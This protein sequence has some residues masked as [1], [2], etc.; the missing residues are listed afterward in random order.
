[1]TDAAAP[2]GEGRSLRGDGRRLARLFVATGRHLAAPPSATGWAAGLG[3]ALATA[4]ASGWKEPIAAA[5]AG[6]GEGVARSVA[7][8]ANVAGAGATVT[9]L[10]VALF[11]LGRWR[12]W[13]ALVD[14][15]LVLAAAGAWCWLLLRVGQIVLAEQR[16]LDGGAMRWFARDG[17]GISGHAA[18]AALLFAPARDILA[19]DA[20]PAVRRGIGAALLVWAALVGWSRMWLGMHFL[21]NVVLGLA[22]GFVAGRAGVEAWRG[23]QDGR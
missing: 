15:A 13:S 4:L 20:P 9:A 7:E 14:A 19:R 6:G 22:L 21:W 8:V 10:G 17:H 12:R 3:V 1:M 18:A 16:P 5:F 2:P 11:A 23:A